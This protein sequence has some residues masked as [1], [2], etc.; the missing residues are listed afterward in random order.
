MAPPT[1]TE[2]AAAFG[3]IVVG[4]RA[5]AEK[6]TD[7]NHLHVTI[8]KVSHKGVSLVNNTNFLIVA[9]IRGD[10]IPLHFVLLFLR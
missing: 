9:V 4:N 8:A 10:G 3:N 6:L 5:Q 7:G 1:R 2:S